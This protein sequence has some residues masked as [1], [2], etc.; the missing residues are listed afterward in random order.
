MAEEEFSIKRTFITHT[1]KQI[2][3]RFTR[4]LP[5]LRVLP[6]GWHKQIFIKVSPK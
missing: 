1:R 2:V 4:S 3:R 6:R 5:N